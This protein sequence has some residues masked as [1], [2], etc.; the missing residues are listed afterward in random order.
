MWRPTSWAD[1][2]ALVGV[3]EETSRLDFKRELG[4]KNEETAK[5]I[6]AMTVN[7]G[8]LAYGVDA[9]KSTGVVRAITPIPLAGVEERLHQI[10]G[11]QIQ[12]TADFKVKSIADPNDPTVGVVA[13]L[14]PAS[15]L[16]PHQVN[17]RYPSR[18][19]TTTEYLDEREIERLYRQRQA[20]SGG[21]TSSGM[22]LDEYA[23]AQL[24]GFQVGDGTGTLTLVVRP[25]GPDISHP[26]GAWQ[27]NAL[28]NAVQ[29]ARQRHASRFANITLVRTFAALGEWKP[30]EARGWAATN[31]GFQ[32]AGTAP[33]ADP[34]VLMGAALAYPA[35][36][37]FRAFFGLR[38]GEHHPSIHTYT[39]AREADVVYELVAMLA[40][41]GEYLADVLGGGHL[42]V[43]SSLSGFQGAVSS[44]TTDT[45]GS[46]ADL[47]AAKLPVAASGVDRVE[48]TSAAE[49]RDKPERVARLLI[50]RWL[51]SFYA[52]DRDLFDTIVP[53]D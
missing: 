34:E 52:D 20:L 50:E 29:E 47:E 42:L 43:A 3:A 4:N 11:S 24:D 32:I 26:A 39:T 49:L 2:E 8:T 25:A 27:Q 9:D 28:Q 51:P 38:R 40:I 23:V 18:R 22:L 19:G 17:G 10:A 13:V 16:A 15:S 48:R 41:T 36:L 21:A 45:L 12:P 53:G 46:V 7:E 44:F 6:A 30:D 5:D 37:S 35:T 33:N 14:I 1:I 31:A